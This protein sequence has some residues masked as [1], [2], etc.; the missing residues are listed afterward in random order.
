LRRVFAAVLLVLVLPARA[1]EDGKV[2]YKFTPDFYSTT[3]EHSAYDINLRGNLGPHAAWIG[4]YRRGEE[5]DQFRVGYEGTFKM[6]FGLLV[7]SAVVATHGFVGGSVNAFIGDRYFGLLG[8]GR[9][10]LADYFNLN[11]DPNDAVT[12][13]TGTRAIPDTTLLLYQVKDNRLDTGQRV[14][15][16]TARTGGYREGVRWTVDVFH[17]RGSE[18]SGSEVVHGTGFSIGCDYRDYF[19]RVAN[20]P[21]VNFTA[22]RMVRLAVGVR[23]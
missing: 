10:N 20:D 2:A 12:F 9:T 7:P 16:I 8:L 11:F 22:D 5:F 23:F 1:E 4:Y 18:T 15:H 21:H 13:G 6:P 14:T 17:K 3:N 19:A